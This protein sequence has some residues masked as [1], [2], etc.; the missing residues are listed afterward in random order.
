MALD[1]EIRR[2]FKQT[3][4]VATP[5]SFTRGGDALY[6]APVA[7]LCICQP[8]SIVTDTSPSGEETVSDFEIITEQ[9]VGKKDHIW[10]PGTNPASAVDARVA[11]RVDT[12]TDEDGTVSHYEVLV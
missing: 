7:A 12:L 3:F 8:V 11:Q 9:A 4:Y 1:P 5:L 10:L 6:N 2:L